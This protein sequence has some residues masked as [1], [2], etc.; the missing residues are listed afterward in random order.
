MSFPAPRAAFFFGVVTLGAI[1][2]AC[3]SSDGEPPESE[4]QGP[5]PRPLIDTVVP[6]T[7]FTAGERVSAQC[8]LLDELGEPADPT[9]VT[10]SVAYDPKS[11]F[12][13]DE[14]RQVR[15]VRAGE[16]SVRCEAPALSLRDESPVAITIVPGAPKRVITQLESD[17]TIAGEPARVS[18]RAF[19]AFGN[20]VHDFARTLA[21]TPG[22][23]GVTAGESAVTMTRA[24]QYEVGCH[25][26][27][28][29]EVESAALLVAPSLPATLSVGLSP[30][31]NFYVIDDQV[32]LTTEVRDR[33]G[34]RVD[35]AA[36][37]YTSE[38]QMPS[39]GRFR[40]TQDGI[41]T[42]GVAVSSPTWEDVVLSQSLSVTVNTTGPDIECLRADD[43]SVPSDAYMIHLAPGSALTVPV[44]VADTFEVDAV[45]IGGRSA[46]K[47]A[48]GHYQ[49]NVPVQFG[50]NF[51]DVVARDKFGQ[52]NSKT[53]FF[54]ASDRWA[55]EN[56]FLGGA[57]GLRFDSFAVD[58]GK[59]PAALDSLN[60]VLHTLL[61]SPGLTALIHQGLLDANP[62][63]EQWCFGTA[64]VN[65]TGGLNLG[66]AS[67]SLRLI[68]GGMRVALDIRN[69][70]LNA[71]LGGGCC[72][73]TNG[74][75]TIQR[76][77]VNADFDL[78]LQGGRLRARIGQPTV[79]VSGL[80]TN[81][82]GTCGWLVDLLDGAITPLVRD[83]L[84][85]FVRNDVGP[86]MDDLLSGLDVSTLAASFAVPKLDGSGTIDLGFGVQMSSLDVNTSRF[87]LGLDTRFTPRVAGH[88]RPTLGVS[89]RSG[90]VL[91][92]P[93]GT[94]TTR[95]VGLA[96]HEG[97]LN[98]ILHG[99]WR[100]G[101]FQSA[102]AFGEESATIDARLPPVAIVNGSRARLMLGGV[103][104]QVAIPG[105][106]DTPLSLT[107]GGWANAD[108]AVSGDD[109]AFGNVTLEQLF[110]S[111][112]VS[113]SQAQR[114]SVGN[115]LTRILQR[116]LADAINNGLPAI[117]IP[118][119]ELPPSVA[120][121][122]LPAGA[123]LGIK[124]PLL[125][126]AD[127]HFVLTG[128]FGVR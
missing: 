95:P 97:T 84:V 99:L 87:L 115:L 74:S 14:A 41:F 93:S 29:D 79:T 127:R 8:V 38:V 109:L 9:G 24:G 121:Y 65:Y 39:P 122:G 54:L 63:A 92:D 53:C 96:L 34:N 59:T 16:A 47:A 51:V 45:T 69:L 49:A 23:D 124:S 77:Q 67:S 17:T 75:A 58:D 100:G 61:N 70:S 27:G 98:Q 44:R 73:T 64:R 103:R 30:E 5:S 71:R 20:E 62:L 56:A 90:N 46:T 13:E 28:A 88:N 117:P 22:G 128:G 11:S 43:P 42:L 108:V 81:F 4:T 94:S 80:D 119:F 111:P 123:Q 3:G 126:T 12:D 48:A 110:V 2:T 114:T 35:D 1:A 68:P 76:L 113:I 101:F 10:F 86:L 107:F 19:D 50:M 31:R 106:I 6:K 125:T 32:T 83:A 85:K 52:E 102:L 120:T 72:T 7:T 21:V 82:G 78:V 40:F 37:R 112:D 104:A 55:A 18:C 66:S 57:L 116:V 33:F 26:S 60:D 15:G 36:L 89:L 91:R 105:V 25:V 118:S